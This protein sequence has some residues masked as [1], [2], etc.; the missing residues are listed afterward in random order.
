MYEI[1]IVLEAIKSGA[2]NPGDVVVRT[3]LPRYEVL[4]IFHILEELGLIEAI[5][6]KGSHKAFRLTKKGEEILD[7]LKK[8]YEIVITV[9][10]NFAQT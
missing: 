8:G 3:N 10:P 2:V 6:S 5:Y 7:G 1:G 9:K 4:A